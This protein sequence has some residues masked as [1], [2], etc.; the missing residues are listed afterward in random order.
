MEPALHGQREAQS[1]QAHGWLCTC[2]RL[3]LRLWGQKT[4]RRCLRQFSLPPLTSLGLRSVHFPQMTN[5]KRAPSWPKLKHSF[6]VAT[7][8]LLVTVW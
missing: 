7:I 2:P 5:L 4:G 3:K 6:Q 8:Y 1:T